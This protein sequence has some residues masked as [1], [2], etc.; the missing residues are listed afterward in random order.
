MAL[1]KGPLVI[2]EKSLRFC[3]QLRIGNQKER[4]KKRRKGKGEGG[5]ERGL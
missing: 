2:M 1:K 5:K 3:R 4:D